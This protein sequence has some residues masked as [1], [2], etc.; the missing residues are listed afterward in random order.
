MKAQAS[1]SDLAE[2]A[3]WVA[4]AISPKPFTP[5]LAGMI[6]SA[7]DGK[8]ILRASDFDSALIAEVEAEVSEPETILVPGHAFAAY[9]A[10]ARGDV[11]SLVRENTT[12]SLKAGKSRSEFRTLDPEEYPSGLHQPSACVAT[13]ERAERLRDLVHPLLGHADPDAPTPWG[14][15]VRLVI[16]GDDMSL[17][18]GTRYALG[19]A[20]ATEWDPVADADLLILASQFEKVIAGLS[21]Q[22]M[23]WHD[24]GSG[25]VTFSTATR[26][27]QVRMI[28]A[29]YPDVYVI[30]DA[31]RSG[32]MVIEKRDLEAA[33]KLA[34][35]G[36]DRVVFDFDRDHLEVTS[37]SPEKGELAG[38]ITDEVPCDA[39]FPG[40]FALNTGYVLTALAAMK[41]GKIALNYP[42]N[43]DRKCPVLITD[44]SARHVIGPVQ[45]SPKE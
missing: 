33:I 45:V 20:Q 28:D 21:G 25:P 36:T 30:M 35:T 32:S 3:R 37:L 40:R 5:I 10:A 8:I 34:T 22:M 43:G 39:N 24:G 4:R 15:A 27:A 41:P 12:L 6:I 26:T 44:G 1:R 18:C 38:V 16:N 31:Q 11:V 42:T 2:A 29:N 13:M 7:D 14:A 17:M 19:V 9:L 23:I